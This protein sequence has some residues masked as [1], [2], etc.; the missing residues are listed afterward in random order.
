M[1]NL[2]T[3][4]AVVGRNARMEWVSGSFGSCVSML[5]PMTI[6]RRSFGLRVHRDYFCRREG[7]TLDTGSKVIHLGKEPQLNI[8]SKSISKSGGTAIYRGPLRIR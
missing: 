4:R 8:N 6:L 5:Y 2:N 3:K 1:Y 7:Q